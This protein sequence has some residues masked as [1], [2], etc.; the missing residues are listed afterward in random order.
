MI[1]RETNRQQATNKYLVLFAENIINLSGPIISGAETITFLVKKLS[2]YQ[3]DGKW[4][5]QVST[6][7]PIPH[8]PCQD[9]VKR[10]TE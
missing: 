9:Q 8:P 3:E 7:H 2:I 5:S 10:R 6:R 4:A 1:Q